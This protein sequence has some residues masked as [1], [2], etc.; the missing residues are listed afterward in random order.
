MIKTLTTKKCTLTR[1]SPGDGERVKRLKAQKSRRL[2][3]AL[4]A[5]TVVFVTLIT[6]SCARHAADAHP[7]PATSGSGN[8]DESRARLFSV[9]Q[10]QMS[11]V[12][13][14]TIEPTPLRREL[15]LSG[16]VAYNSF[17]TTPVIT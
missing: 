4:V 16:S 2:T 1:K 8:S 9:P 11:H 3:T 13:L 6:A 10:E 17:E 7:A 5:A 14:V 12:Q 15:R